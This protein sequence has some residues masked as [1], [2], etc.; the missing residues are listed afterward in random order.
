MKKLLVATIVALGLTGCTTAP[1]QPSEGIM[2]S[3]V[4]APLALE[5]NKTDLGHKVG[6]ASSISILGLFATGD[7]STQAA[8]KDGGIKTVKH[9][10]YEFK[11]I[12]FGIFTKTTVYVY[13]D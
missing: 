4:K 8:A 2:Y 3:D 5:Y 12:L 7:C 1:F 6:S 11:N 13:G 10:D 9:A